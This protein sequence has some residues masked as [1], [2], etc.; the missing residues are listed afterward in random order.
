MTE[1]IRSTLEL[2]RDAL[3]ATGRS[4]A[5]G[6][7]IALAVVV[8]AGI[9][10]VASAIAAPL[11][12]LGGF[13]LGAVNALLIGATLSLVEQAVSSP[14]QLNLNDIK[15]SFGQYFWEVITVGFVLW[16][17]IML[18][19]QGAAA[20]P[21]GPFLAA[22]IFLLLFILLNPAPEVIYRI[23]PGS[24]LDVIRLSYEFVVQNWIE[25]FLPLALA[26]APF[27]L[28]FFFTISERM[29]RGALLDFF[30][31]LIL[32]FRLLQGWLSYLGLPDVASSTLVLLLT[33]LATVA[34]LVFRGHLF[35]A[36]HGS[37]RRK[38]AFQGRL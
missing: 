33:P 37:S 12:I 30:Q 24:P 11:G 13:L 20:N 28:S 31:I 3:H 16:L 25:W 4:L 6:W 10:L 29:G 35:A 5:R 22:A 27:G 21:Y 23:R 9:M 8:F 17:P 7:I 26:V 1:V 36:L 2:Y 19:D 15:S 18:I 38:R 32:P 34:M 14:R